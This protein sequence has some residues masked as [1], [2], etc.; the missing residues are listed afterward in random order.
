MEDK[1]IK[2]RC[3]DFATRGG[4]IHGFVP[5]QIVK[6]AEVFYNWVTEG[7]EDKPKMAPQKPK[8]PKRKRG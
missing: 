4:G 1:E 3:I 2:I 6:H 7:N 5:G 8:K